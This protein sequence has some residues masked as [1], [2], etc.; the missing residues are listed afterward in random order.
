MS[1]EQI[2]ARI[3]QLKQE[4]EQLLAE[5]NKQIGMKIGAIDELERLLAEITK[6]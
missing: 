3:A 2:E 6:E 1:K 4:L 5:A